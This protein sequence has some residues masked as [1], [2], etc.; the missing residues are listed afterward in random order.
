[1][2]V[3]SFPVVRDRDC[4]V[5]EIAFVCFH[6][7][8]IGTVRSTPRRFRR[9]CESISGHLWM[10]AALEAAWAIECLS[11]SIWG[12]KGMGCRS[13]GERLWRARR[14]TKWRATLK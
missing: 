2:H 8:P 1:M 5:L 7:I 12:G 4:V 13:S 3:G 10:L 11:W 9:S 14:S 6:I